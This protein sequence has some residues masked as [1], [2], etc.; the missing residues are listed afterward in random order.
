MNYA[1]SKKKKIHAVDC[2]ML[3]I[4]EIKSFVVWLDALQI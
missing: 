2:T 1:E 4:Q 3:N